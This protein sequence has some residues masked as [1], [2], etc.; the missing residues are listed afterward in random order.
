M[1]GLRQLEDRILTAIMVVALMVPLVL[2]AISQGNKPTLS[3][4]GTQIQVREDGSVQLLFDVCINNAPMTTGA[5]FTLRYNPQYILPSDYTSNAVL[6]NRSSSDPAFFKNPD[7]YQENI[8]G[9]LVPVDP[10]EKPMTN[11]LVM[12]SD[13]GTQGSIQVILFTNG[14]IVPG[15]GSGMTSV[16]TGEG[17]GALLKR[18]VFDASRKLKLG[19]LS[20]RVMDTDLLPEIVR[21]FNGVG[22]DV[23]GKAVGVLLE[24]N[25]AKGD[26]LDK[27]IFFDDRAGRLGLNPWGIGLCVEGESHGYEY[28]TWNDANNDEKAQATFSYVFPKTIIKARA[29][30]AELTLNAYQVYTDGHVSDVD[31]ALQK[32]SPAITVTY[33]DGSQGN[34]IMPWGRT[35]NAVDSDGNNIVVD[36]NGDV[37]SALPWAATVVTDRN[38]AT[39]RV[40]KD[41]VTDTTK[42]IQYDPTASRY[43]TAG[44]N[45]LY[46]VEKSFC[47][48]EGGQAKTFPIPIQVNLTVTPITLVDVTAN[49]LHK[50]YIL[51]D[52]LVS[53]EAPVQSLGALQ[54]PT[55]AR[56][57]TDVPAG[58]ATLIMDIPGWSNEQK[59]Q[60]GTTEYWP[61][62]STGSTMDKLWKD[63]ATDDGAAVNASIYLHWPTAA[64]QGKFVT[65]PPATAPASEGNGAYLG[66]NRAGLYTFKMA[67]AYGGTPTAFQ[68]PA[69]QTA[70]PWLT[71]PDNNAVAGDPEAWPIDDATRRIVWNGEPKEDPDD[72]DKPALVDTNRYQV[73]YVSTITN[74]SNSQ[75]DLTLQVKRV[76]GTTIESLKPDSV[77]RI[78]L[79]DGTELGT[80]YEDD[81]VTLADWFDHGT[82]GRYEP[83]ENMNVDVDFP[84]A[85]RGF[86]LT[87]NPGDPTTGNY[88]GD[89]EK[90][91][92]YINLGGWFS[93]AVKE[94]DDT[95]GEKTLWSDF[96]PVYV[97][98]R[99]NYYEESKT[100]NFIGENAG[101]YPWP[102]G[103]STT[104][105]LPPGT[106]DPVTINAANT[107]VP[108]YESE[109]DGVTRTT[110]RYGILTTYDGSTGAQPG[111]LQTF[112]IDP[113]PSPDPDNDWRKTGPVSVSTAD[114]TARSVTTYGSEVFLDSAVYNAYGKVLNRLTD[115]TLMQKVYAPDASTA[116]V[117][118][119]ELKKDDLIEAIVL[120]YV[121]TSGGE[122]SINT[123]GPNVS[124]VIYEARTQGYT[125]RQDYTLVIRNI[126]D[127]D[128]NGLSIDTFTDLMSNSAYNKDLDVGGGHFELLK[129]PAS[130]LPAG[131]STTFV[132]TYVYDLRANGSKAMD[133]KD[134]LFITS[135]RKNRTGD[136][137]VAGTDYLLDFD[138]QFQVTSQNIH[139]VFVNVVP[140]DECMGT[141]G[142]IVGEVT[143]G[144]GNTMMNTTAGTTAFSQGSRV[145]FMVSPKDEYLHNQELMTVVDSTGNKVET[146]RYEPPEGVTLPD[147][148]E[149]YTFVM[150]DYDT[151]VTIYFYEP[152]SSKLRLSALRVYA[153]EQEANL[154]HPDPDDPRD[155]TAWDS[156]KEQYRQTIWQKTYTKAER[157]KS[158]EYAANGDGKN[159]SLMTMGTADKPGFDSQ[160]NQYLTVIPADADWAQVE[161]DLR[162]VEYLV[163]GNQALTGIN[164]E[165][166]L[167]STKDVNVM[168]Q[169][170]GYK[171]I[172]P[173]DYLGY[174]TGETNGPTTHTSI[175][176]ESPQPGNSKYVRILLTYKG[177]DM[178]ESV[179][180]AY[181]IEIHR[182]PKTV[183][184]ELN[185]GNSPY[186]MIMNDTNITGKEAA[187]KA[188]VNNQYSFSGLTTGVPSVVT[189]ENGLLDLHYWIEAWAPPTE[190]WS[191]PNADWRT[192]EAVYDSDT[193]M[194]KALYYQLS[195]WR[196]DDEKK[197]DVITTSSNSYNL[198][199]NDYAFFAIM[200]EEFR[201]PG[202]KRATDSS[203][204]AVDLTKAVISLQAYTLDADAD[205]NIPGGQL[206]RFGLPTDPDMLKARTITFGFLDAGDGTAAVSGDTVRSDWALWY[207]GA[208]GSLVQT[209]GAENTL[210][211]LRPG[212]YQLAYTFP[213]YNYIK[214]DPIYGNS[215]LTVT[216]DFVV[217]APV[218][219]VNADL[220]VADTVD[221]T[222]MEGRIS[223]NAGYPAL[224]Y[225]A[226]NYDYAAIFKLR[227]CDVN[228]DRNIN[229]I[230]ANTIREHTTVK[231]FYL[232]VGYGPTAA[233]P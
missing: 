140:A 29:A 61:S 205:A 111:R 78:M 193:G 30:E 115:R 20:F 207:R 92:R 171:S 122:R 167:Y 8:G 159:L 152:I 79:P 102:G 182:A 127:V 149:I 57:V 223:P 179:T 116:L 187:K 147:N 142:V 170:G 53:G 120:E 188:F 112:T 126:G 91:R 51:N 17:T 97:P 161:A 194:G 67:T 2:V 133:Y 41:A 224:G 19:T 233:T 114:G 148:V 158:D 216:R 219:D 141:A 77:F 35:S 210:L 197:Q 9:Q 151:T 24:G 26:S 124:A 47:Y 204:R 209:E 60:D 68:R 18:N 54:L 14:S 123:I 222:L 11:T 131:E 88:G 49:D 144:F 213:D 162:K 70:Y 226:D 73:T 16:E 15:I 165:M 192:S 76:S 201:D 69:I 94:A 190:T 45:Q 218:G 98:P 160:V 119:E 50:S 139:R 166:L 74:N 96:I 34:F 220:T 221:K 84:G 107:I 72:P 168:Q 230:D 66:T 12:Y 175:P 21:K 231:R 38:D 156:V 52:D 157:D 172:Y 27:L 110:E 6:E 3:F 184:A 75:P 173:Q 87:T 10:F 64:D 132:L 195:G 37:I 174:H 83:K 7:L 153:D 43:K 130:F 93:V 63:G 89:R 146:T 117:R 176:F 200:G 208:D 40:V 56:L 186:G 136:D 125:M 155:T 189:K 227:T 191:A 65:V 225:M 5:Q 105:I 48:E 100:Y 81:A 95:T 42:E 154:F 134:K 55:Q 169:D 181:Y 178:S 217:L 206:E 135:N 177:D 232:P 36:S 82:N 4:E 31:A 104:V 128:I 28:V 203:G 121:S 198:D 183:D 229:N 86:D 164:V 196:Y 143:D 59:H 129:P 113:E 33:S 71:I 150:P 202:I 90:L 46:L 39:N 212:R 80:G 211:Q 101:L 22:I 145:Y 44:A 108:V 25:H 23:N 180:R 109:S 58:G 138:A 137:C 62:E 99:D 85:K 214:D 199:L 118:T 13:S 32:Y 228:N 103:L 215:Y 163:N 1:K 106:Y 185:Y